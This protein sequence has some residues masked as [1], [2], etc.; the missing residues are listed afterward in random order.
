VF[1]KSH[2]KT[3]RMF[4][5]FLKSKK[6]QKN[7]FF[8]SKYAKNDFVKILLKDFEMASHF[9]G[10]TKHVT[11]LESDA[12]LLGLYQKQNKNEPTEENV[13][14]DEEIKVKETSLASDK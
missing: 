8:F 11:L 5:K 9:L 1:V 4:Y 12:K 14:K 7:Y 2:Q 13:K 3:I 10:A 6:S